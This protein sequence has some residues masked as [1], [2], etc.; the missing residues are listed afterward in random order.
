MVENLKRRERERILKE[1]NE[2]IERE[3]ETMLRNER[4]KLVDEKLA[5]E[6]LEH[7]RK[8]LEEERRTKEILD[9]QTYESARLLEIQRRQHEEVFTYRKIYLNI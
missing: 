6:K 3:K 8:V 2:E 4:Q 1:V 5:F 9:K 7:D